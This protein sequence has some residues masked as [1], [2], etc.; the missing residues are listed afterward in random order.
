MG[1][2]S[3]MAAEVNKL[4]GNRLLSG[5]AV[6]LPEV[7]SLCITMSTSH[8]KRVE[9]MIEPQGQSLV[10]VIKERA[11]CTD[12]ESLL[13]YQRWLEEVRLDS[14]LTIEGVGE[15]R[16]NGFVTADSFAK[17]LNPIVV[18]EPE[19]AP[20]PV[21]APVPAPK[22]A[23][24]KI[25]KQNSDKKPMTTTPEKKSSKGLIY[26]I[27]AVVVLLIGG[28]FI[29]SN[30]SE[31]RAEA[32]RIEAEAE[33][34]IK[35]AQRV[36]DSIKI[37]NLEAQRLAEEA[38]KVVEP[39]RYRWVYGVFAEQS[40]VDNAVK[41]INST[42]GEGTAKCYPFGACTLVSMFE[43]NNRAECQRLLM[44]NY[45]TYP[46]SWIYELK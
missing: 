25:V 37:A 42:F 28:Y 23:P 2:I 8:R 22:P 33:A 46:D 45:D 12:E 38:A 9:F 34:K 27:I 15:L 35:E 7:G 39:L 24:K 4:V 13:I 1:Q 10:E 20:E 32:A 30:I 21:S 44:D 5:E 43:S 29:Y 11:K 3:K 36:A 17:E 19:P 40:N 6:H 18:A 41:F 14:T 31:S 26:T 16:A